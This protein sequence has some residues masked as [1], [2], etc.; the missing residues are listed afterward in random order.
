MSGLGLFLVSFSFLILYSFLFYVHWCFASMY[1]CVRD[2]DLGITDS[3]L[4]AISVLGIEP[5]SPGRAVS[6]L[7]Y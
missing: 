7:N 2:L 5:V 6:A 1:G 4:G 3:C